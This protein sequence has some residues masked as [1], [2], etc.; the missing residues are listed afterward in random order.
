MIAASSTSSRAVVPAGLTSE[1]SPGACP[2]MDAR[3]VY[4]P[5]LSA[6]SASSR[7]G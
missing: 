7:R 1:K 3:R 5:A 4:L 2:A 6:C